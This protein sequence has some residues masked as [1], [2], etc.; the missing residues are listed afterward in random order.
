MGMLREE[1]GGLVKAKD[2]K[3]RLLAA[4]ALLAAI[5]TAG[6]D[7]LGI[8]VS[9]QNKAQLLDAIAEASDGRGRLNQDLVVTF[10]ADC[11][12]MVV[13]ETDI[14]NASEK[15]LLDCG[16]HKIRLDAGG[17]PSGTVVFGDPDGERR[18]DRPVA[19]KGCGKG[20]VFKNLTLINHGRVEFDSVED[21]LAK[22]CDF[23]N[24]G[25]IAGLEAGGAIK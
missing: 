9:V 19:I 21:T 3:G 4:V 23:I 2:A 8:T 5:A 13:G 18:G 20:S 6:M 11:A 7:A 24:C 15:C 25:T 17:C 12:P 16:G 22:D 10:A 14:W 1:T